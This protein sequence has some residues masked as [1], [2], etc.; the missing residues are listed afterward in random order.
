MH[1]A[2]GFLPPIHAAAWTVAAAPFVIHGAIAVVRQVRT[3]PE[4]RL[5]L[6]AA[7]A[8]TFVLSAIKLP[9]V[10]GSSSHPT[11]TGLGAVLFR[12]PVMAFLGTVVLLFQAL[13]LAHGGITTLG[14]NAFSF[15]IVG[16]WVGYGAWRL[17][18]G[19]GAPKAVGIFAAMFFADMA[20]Y[21]T[22]SLQLALGF[23]DPTSGLLGAG[24]KFLSVFAVTQIPLAVI[25]GLL[26]VLVFGVLQRVAGP[27]M[28]R[29]GVLRKT[30]LAGNSRLEGDR[31]A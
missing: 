3:H 15:A 8:F 30:N 7:G 31:V 10:T 2:E 20:T 19:L 21:C 12:P 9:S 1:I 17:V 23:P 18:V 25:E 22:T 5:L 24:V 27:E 29:L 26:G 6:G 4:T 11:G 14:A 13:L 16:P 28:M